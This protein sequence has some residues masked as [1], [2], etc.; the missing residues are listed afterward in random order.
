MF[1]ETI[2]SIILLKPLPFKFSREQRPFTRSTSSSLFVENYIILKIAQH[3]VPILCHELLDLALLHVQYFHGH[4]PDVHPVE[5]D[6][7][8]HLQLGALY[9]Q[10]EVVNYW[11]SSC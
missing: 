1:K 2:R 7:V 3:P 11:I 4:H 5:W 8:K 6:R 10:A 9:V